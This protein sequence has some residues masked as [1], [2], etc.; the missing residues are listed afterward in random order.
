MLQVIFGD[1]EHT[2]SE[3]P[4]ARLMKTRKWLYLSSASAILLSNNL[5]DTKAINDVLKIVE[6]PPHLLGAALVGGLIYMIIQ[7]ALLTMQL[8]CVY[9]IVLNERFRFRR[10]DELAAARTRVSEADKKVRTIT[11]TVSDH[12]NMVAFRQRTQAL[13]DDE[14]LVRFG[15]SADALAQSYAVEKENGFSGLSSYDVAQ[16]KL[17]SIEIDRNE[18]SAAMSAMMDH[19]NRENSFR[20]A[21]EDVRTAEETYKAISMQNPADRPVYRVVESGIDIARL[22]PP[23]VFAIWALVAVLIALPNMA[24][25]TTSNKKSVIAPRLIETAK[26]LHDK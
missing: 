14:K 26:K 17:E 3:G 18:I 15:M 10:E 12:P 7:Y 2:A 8:C 5:V 1:D 20:E 23:A 24:L 22:M 6:T 21:V 4:Y 11:R 13:D 25:T 9:D 16:L 19:L